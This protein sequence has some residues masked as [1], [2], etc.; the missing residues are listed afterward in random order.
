MRSPIE[1]TSDAKPPSLPTAAQQDL[2][3]QLQDKESVHI[4][5]ASEVVV[6][7]VCLG[8]ALAQ[9]DAE[10]NVLSQRLES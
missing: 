7:A 2:V 1:A 6:K 4:V 10:A 9:A 8:T 3:Q 5:I